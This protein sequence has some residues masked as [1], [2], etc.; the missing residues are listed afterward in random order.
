MTK[1]QKPKTTKPKPKVTT[2]DD[3]NPPKPPT[4]PPGK[5]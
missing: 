1:K 3:E 5:G 4:K 2:L